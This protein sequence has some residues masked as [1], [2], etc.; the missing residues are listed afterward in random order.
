MDGQMGSLAG[1][2]L[3]IDWIKIVT[4]YNTYVLNFL[5]AETKILA[6]DKAQI[7]LS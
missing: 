2:V 3:W 4:R 1:F 7:T 6:S 5:R